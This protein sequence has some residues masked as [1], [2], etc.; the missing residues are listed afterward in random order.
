MV[1][2]VA[3]KRAARKTPIVEANT[4][5]TGDQAL[6]YIGARSSAGALLTKSMPRICR[7]LE[8]LHSG[9]INGKTTGLWASYVDGTITL[10]HDLIGFILK[11]V[12]ALHFRQLSIYILTYGLD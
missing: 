1:Q 3:R 6:L 7:A 12:Y 9:L 2:R 5:P 10:H 4:L 8:G 11:H